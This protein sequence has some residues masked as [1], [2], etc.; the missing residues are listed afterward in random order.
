MTI[1]TELQAVYATAP[2]DVYYIETLSLEHPA[3]ENGI[4][5]LTNHNGGWIGD[6]GDGVVATYEYAPFAAVPPANADQGN[7]TL[8]VGID[9]AGRELMLELE[10]LSL[11][12]SQPIEVVYRVYLSNAGGVLQNDPPLKLSVSSVTAT[13]DIV[14]FSAT[15]TNLRNRPFPAV[16]YTTEQFPGL[17]R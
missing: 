3:F 13:T 4:R 5:F 8:Q 14:A 1:S 15:L 2:V 11:V 12:P 17:E 6:M 16:L 9:N 10:R 7:V